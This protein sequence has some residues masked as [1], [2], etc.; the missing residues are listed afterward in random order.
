MKKIQNYLLL[1]WIFYRTSVLTVMM[2]F[3]N[4]FSLIVVKQPIVH[5]RLIFDAS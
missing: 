5:E 1:A 3:W 2:Q 4:S